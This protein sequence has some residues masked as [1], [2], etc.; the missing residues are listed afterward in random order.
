[1]TVHLS[2][3]SSNRFDIVEAPFRARAVR[4][5]AISELF[6]LPKGM[7]HFAHTMS[8]VQI[9]QALAL[10]FG[11]MTSV[12]GSEDDCSVLVRV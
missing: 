11:A 2:R 6:G 1:M 12:T 7:R 9:K 8:T 4:Q 3:F 10:T 5:E